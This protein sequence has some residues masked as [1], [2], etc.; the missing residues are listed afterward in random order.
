MSV[1]KPHFNP[2]LF[3]RN[4]L[5]PNLS[6]ARKKIKSPSEDGQSAVTPT[7]NTGI[8]LECFIFDCF[9]M[10]AKMAVLEGPRD[11]EFSPGEWLFAR[12]DLRLHARTTHC[13]LLLFDPPVKNAPG[14]PKDSPDSARAM[15]T[16]QN[17]KW[18]AAAGIEVTGEGQIELGPFVTY[19]GEGLEV[20]KEEPFNGK[21]DATSDV[22]ID[23]PAPGGKAAT[24]SS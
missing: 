22:C 6:P 1:S 14:N 21:V 20:L 15:L 16:A 3:A 19:R 13:P 2:D 5:G 11:E 12:I 9:G 23:A 17:K 10:A 7:E 8:K 4:S 24:T 18:L